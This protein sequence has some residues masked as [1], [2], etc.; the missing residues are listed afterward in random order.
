MVKKTKIYEIVVRTAGEG[1]SVYDIESDEDLAEAL[2]HIRKTDCKDDPFEENFVQNDTVDFWQRKPL[3]F[4]ALDMAK[5][6]ERDMFGFPMLPVGVPSPAFWDP[7]N[8]F[9]PLGVPKSSP[10]PSSFTHY[11]SDPGVKVP[12]SQPFTLEMFTGIIEKIRNRPGVNNCPYTAANK[13][14]V[15]RGL[16]PWPIGDSACDHEPVNMGFMHRRMVCKKCNKDIE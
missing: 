12:Q 1:T 16:M 9:T 6:I 14:R 7:H 13:D 3:D 11:A 5:A 15:E 4:A 8:D 10:A 2:E